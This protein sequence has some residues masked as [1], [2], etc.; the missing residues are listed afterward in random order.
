MT[1]KANPNCKLG[2]YGTGEIYTTPC[3]CT[4]IQEHSNASQILDKAADVYCGGVN[5]KTE[6]DEWV[7]GERCFKAGAEWA[8]RNDPRVLA[9]VKV[10][11]KIGTDDDGSGG[12]I[13]IMGDPVKIMERW[14]DE[15]LAQYRK[16]IERINKNG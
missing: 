10:L 14:A 4:I 16:A 12:N 2:C 15:T 9:L 5:L 7:S 8:V 6:S 13:I 11:S 3:C 1:N